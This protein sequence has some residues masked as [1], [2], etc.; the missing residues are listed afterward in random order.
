MCHSQGGGGEPRNG[1]ESIFVPP[2]TPHPV[3]VCARARML[4]GVQASCSPHL[5]AFLEGV[6]SAGLWN[7][8]N[9]L[10]LWRHPSQ[11][12][13]ASISPPGRMTFGLCPPAGSRR[14]C[15][16]LLSA[17]Q[18]DCSRTSVAGG[19][20]ARTPNQVRPVHQSCPGGPLPHSQTFTPACDGGAV[21]AIDRAGWEHQTGEFAHPS[22]AAEVSRLVPGPV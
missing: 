6:S 7:Q 14:S 15:S 5:A 19:E 21:V 12:E 2:P 1:P 22:V 13:E 8:Q 20:T 3:L 11:P 17:G 10:R 4:A 9:L 16:F 18:I